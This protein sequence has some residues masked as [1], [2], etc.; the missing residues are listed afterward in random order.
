MDGM[1]TIPSGING[2]WRKQSIKDAQS[3]LTLSEVL[4]RRMTRLSWKRFCKIFQNL[5]HRKTYLGGM[6]A[7]GL[8]FYSFS[9]TLLC[10][11]SKT[12]PQIP[13]F[14]E[15]RGWSPLSCERSQLPAGSLVTH[16]RSTLTACKH[17][18]QSSLNLPHSR[19]ERFIRPRQITNTDNSLYARMVMACTWYCSWESWESHFNINN[20]KMTN[21]KCHL[22]VWHNPFH[23]HMIERSSC[24]H[25]GNSYSGKITSLCWHA[26]HCQN[27][28]DMG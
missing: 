14:R 3:S 2:S 6:D 24:L 1:M 7:E 12:Y 18:S 10:L 23:Q 13:V 9:G 22:S 8:H 15:P 19:T 11:R 17:D 21:K 25:I 16:P 28:W 20:I 4:P 27:S 26:P 5:L